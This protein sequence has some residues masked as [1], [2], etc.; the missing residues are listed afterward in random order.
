MQKAYAGIGARTTP[1]EYQQYMKLAA[2]QL[3][4]NNLI[5][6]SGGA[7]GADSAFE[8]GAGPNNHHFFRR[9]E[10]YLPWSGFNRHSDDG[11]IWPNAKSVQ[12]ANEISRVHHPYWEKLSGTVKSLMARNTFQIL[13][14]NLDDPALFVL[15]W[16]DGGKGHGGTGQAIR[17]A[18]TYKIPV[19]DMGGMSLDH[20]AQSLNQLLELL[21]SE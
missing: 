21:R 12:K 8:E 18:K 3:R 4:E 14:Q 6:R 13:G 1:P 19:F 16:T 10:I 7:S 9:K 11:V 15:C 2:Q 5:L 20:I 17:I